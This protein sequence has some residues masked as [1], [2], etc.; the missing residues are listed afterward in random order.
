MIKIL[1]IDDDAIK[2]ERIKREVFS[3]PELAKEE[4]L[5]AQ[6]LVEA[7]DLLTRRYFDLV[8]LDIFL[9]PTR[10]A[11][12]SRDGG[13]QFLRELSL[14]NTLIKPAHVIGLTAYDLALSGAD[15]TFREELWRVIKFD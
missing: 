6:D 13:V 4:V 5:V 7:R 12:P 10:G 2:A 11:D 8:I 1:I 9:P 15:S 14:S 3:I